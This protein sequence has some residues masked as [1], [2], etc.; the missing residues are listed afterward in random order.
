METLVSL[1]RHKYNGVY[2]NPGDTFTA[3]RQHAK[4]LKVCKLAKDYVI[5]EPK[6]EPPKKAEPVKAQEVEAKD[7]TADAPK[8]RG[9]PPGSY[10]RKDMVADD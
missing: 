6:S 10:Q 7:M 5:P 1:K 4:A 8:R 9:R 3:T 2:N